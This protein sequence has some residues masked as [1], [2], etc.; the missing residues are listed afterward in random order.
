MTHALMQTSGQKLARRAS[1]TEMSCAPLG[2]HPS[3]F[4]PSPKGNLRACSST[5]QIRNTFCEESK[6]TPPLQS[7]EILCSSHRADDFKTNNV[8]GTLLALCNTQHHISICDPKPNL[9]QLR[10]MTSAL[11]C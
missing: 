10:C 1:V 11:L 2:H 4:E 3:A 6:E 5:A 7:T 9:I 8:V